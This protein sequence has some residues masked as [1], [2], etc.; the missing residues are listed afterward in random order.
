MHH[1]LIESSRPL[2]VSPLCSGLGVTPIDAGL[3][4]EAVQ[5]VRVG[6]LRLTRPPAERRTPMGGYSHYVSYDDGR[7]LTAFRTSAAVK[8]WMSLRSLALAAPLP[9]DDD[10]FSTR[11]IGGYREALHFDANRF[12][13]LSCFQATRV[14]NAGHYTLALLTASDDG[15]VTVHTLHQSCQPRVD[16]DFAESR[17]REDN[18]LV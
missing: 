4:N 2:R 10:S 13:A 9:K 17:R 12:F 5:I 6:R 7:P 18:G 8:L 3:R 16:F 11:V 15:E 14:M 1:Q